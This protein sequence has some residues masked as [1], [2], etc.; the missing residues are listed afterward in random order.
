MD[1]ILTIR[2]DLIGRSEGD[3]DERQVGFRKSLSVFVVLMVLNG[4][5]ICLCIVLC[6]VCEFLF[7]YL[8]FL[9]L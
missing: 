2:R 4:L 9:S 8:L 3:D 1:S 7:I 6:H 5:S